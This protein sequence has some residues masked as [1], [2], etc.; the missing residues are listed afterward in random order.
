M[1]TRQNI[2]NQFVTDISAMTVV[3]LQEVHQKQPTLADVEKLS[4][5]SAF[6]YTG[7]ETRVEDSRAVI[8]Y[9]NW[10]MEVVVEVWSKEDNLESILEEIHAAIFADY[11]LGGNAV[12]AKR[13]G[14]DTWILDYEGT[15]YVLYIPF[16]VFFRHVRGI[17]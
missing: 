9:E 3:P 2:L 1:S 8:G 13:L 7:V 15:W 14:S 16:A 12:E 17:M 11:T 5:P 6:V 4:F 10:D